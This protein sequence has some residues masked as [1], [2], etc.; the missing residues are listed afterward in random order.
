MSGRKQFDVDEVGNQVMRTFWQ[1]GYADTSLGDLTAA[2]GLGKGSLYG[3]FGDKDQM[4]RDALRRYSATHG[5]RF[6]EAMTSQQ[7]N[8]VRAVEAYFEVILARIA[9]PAVPDGCLVAQSA[10]HLPALSPDSA[11][12]VRALLDT[13][14]GVVRAALAGTTTDAE[15][16]DEL[17]GYVVAVNQ[18]LAV[19]SRAG[20][21]TEELRAVTRL[22]CDTVACRLRRAAPPDTASAGS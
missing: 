1:R 5:A 8:P 11:A 16:L 2:T 9:D 15:T 21:T 4:F 3:T 17:A 18:S 10:A 19:L 14:R 20:S 6:R 12:D 22:A 7:D 13:Q